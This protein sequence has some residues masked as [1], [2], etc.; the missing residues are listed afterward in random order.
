MTGLTSADC[1]GRTRLLILQSTPFCNIDCSYC[2]LP[3]RSER[4]R[5]P[6]EIVE[7]AV[8]FVFD[9]SLA[10]PDFTVVWHAGEPLVLP[11]DWYREAFAAVCRGAPA[12][13]LIPQSV[14][15]NGILVTDE[16]CSFF[17]DYAVRVGVSLDGPAT[18]HDAKRRTRSN[19]GTHANVMRGIETLRRNGV[20]FHIICVIGAETLDAADELMD[21]F[22]AEGIRDVGFNI[23]EIEGVHRTSSLDRSDI[24]PR[25]RDFFGRLLDR[26]EAANPPL[27]I[28]EREELLATLRHPE[29]GRLARN[30]QNDPLGFLSV[31]SRG[32]LYTFSPE[33]AGLTDPYYGNMIVGQLPGADLSAL[34][35]SPVFQRMWSDIEH[36]T[37]MCRRSCPYFDV[38][39]GGAPVNKLA[40][41][42][43]FAARETLYCRLSHQA[44]ADA[45][46]L[47]LE[48]K[49]NS[50]KLTA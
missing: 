30:T 31:S 14:Q 42:G 27:S 13:T 1:A 18:L 29:F 8:A 22:I 2:Y 5:M 24:D 6:F 20:P 43:T 34:L 50:K 23:E 48:T 16:W 28:R 12:G 38:C 45:V 26:A 11:V 36:G 9:H 3:A 41:C 10:A 15:T 35:S 7:A 17:R 25:F 49:L 4:H 44:I 21:F 39:L 33:L 37:D 47:R 32:E 40:E 19:K 46:L